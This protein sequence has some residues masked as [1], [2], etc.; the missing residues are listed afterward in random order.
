MSLTP[1]DAPYTPIDRLCGLP[2]PTMPILILSPFDFAAGVSA[3]SWRA[4]QSGRPA[5][6]RAVRDDCKKPRRERL[7]QFIARIPAGTGRD[8]MAS[9][10]RAAPPV[11][12]ARFGLFRRRRGG[13]ERPILGPAEGG[14]S[15]TGPA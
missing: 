5:A 2:T 9:S 13:I 10:Y 12:R 15:R 11:S 4:Y 6:P 14:R 7:P 3:R 1:F 8:R